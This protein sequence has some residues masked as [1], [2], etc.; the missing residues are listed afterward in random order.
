LK[1]IL[2]WRLRRFGRGIG[3]LS[4]WK[5]NFYYKKMTK[6]KKIKKIDVD[7]SKVVWYSWIT[8]FTSLMGCGGKE[9]VYS[10]STRDVV[11]GLHKDVVEKINEIIDTLNAGIPT[12]PT[13]AD[14]HKK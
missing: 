13:G 6:N 11:G 10:K 4:C 7:W 1:G 14:D 12:G 2:G 8:R 5:I 3:R 9:G